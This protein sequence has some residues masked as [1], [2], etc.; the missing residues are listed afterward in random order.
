MSDLTNATISGSVSRPQCLAEATES[1]IERDLR[2]FELWVFSRA[3]LRTPESAG[4]LKQKFFLRCR[5][6]KAL[7]GLLDQFARP[8]F[9][10]RQPREC[11]TDR[12]AFWQDGLDG[13]VRLEKPD[14]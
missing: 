1:A 6:T 14:K 3:R 4:L 9:L 7:A 10:V 11:A 5:E 8:R 2:A 12:R 13:H